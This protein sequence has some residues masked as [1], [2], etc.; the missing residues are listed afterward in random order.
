[1]KRFLLRNWWVATFILMAVAFYIEALY[2]KNQLTSLLQGKASMLK[3]EKRKGMLKKEQ[4]LL[5][6]QSED[7]PEWALLV[8]KERLGVV[9][10]GETKVI[11]R[12]MKTP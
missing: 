1:M 11:F 2:K 10:E 3:D 9:E 6:L 7:D 4:L 5:C 12:E 8:L